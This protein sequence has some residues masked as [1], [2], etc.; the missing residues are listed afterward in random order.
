MVTIN[1][2]VEQIKQNNKGKITQQEFKIIREAR[3]ELEINSEIKK[4]Y[5][6]VATKELTFNSLINLD[7]DILFSTLKHLNL[8]TNI[9]TF[10]LEI[11]QYMTNNM[12]NAFFGTRTLKEAFE[13]TGISNSDDF[14]KLCTD[15]LRGKDYNANIILYVISKISNVSFEIFYSNGH[16]S[17]ICFDRNDDTK[18][19]KMGLVMD[20]V[21]VSL[22]DYNNNASNV[23]PKY[24]KYSTALINLARD[25]NLVCIQTDKP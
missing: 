11:I 22:V 3:Y 8:C 7:E 9:L 4:L 19:K 12:N 1:Q 2:L 18:T 13:A 16:I 24:T 20:C 14:K 25:A 17:D 23:C 15:F 5:S 21:Y 10:K 6:S